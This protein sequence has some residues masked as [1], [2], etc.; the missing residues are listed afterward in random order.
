[1]SV[2]ERRDTPP[3]G[4]AGAAGASAGGEPG[5]GPPLTHRERQWIIV[6]VLLPTFLG[7]LDSTIL[8]SALPTIG[9]DIGHIHDLP[10]LITT[11]LL[12]ATAT[13]PLYG[14]LSDIH[15]RRVI[16]LVGISLY[17]F[18]SL[19]CALAP[20]FG[21]LIGGR[22]VHGLGGGALTG[23]GMVVLGDVA[24]PKQR[25]TYYGYFSVAYASAGALGPLLGGT[26]AQY[27]HW[28]AIFWMNVPAGLIAFT[29]VATLLRRLPRRERRHRLDILG[30][31][32]IVVATVSFM[33]A[34]NVGGIRYA[35]SSPA[36]LTLIG[37]AVFAAA[38]FVLR[39]V[40]AP[41]PLIPIAILGNPVARYAIMANGFGWGAI[42]GLNIFLPIYLQT[43]MGLSAA[44]AGLSLMALMAS[45][46]LSAGLGGQ[47]IGRVE[48]YKRLPMLGLL[49][50]I[51]ALVA[52]ASL[53]TRLTPAGFEVLLVLIGLGFGQV[54]PLSTVAMQ[55]A[56]PPHQFGTAIGTQTFSRNLIGTML[57]AVFAAIV[58]G[59]GLGA[60]SAGPLAGTTPGF[61]N[62]ALGTGFSRIFLAAA[63]TMSLS[64][65]CLC[66]ME[67]KPL[68]ADPL[69]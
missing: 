1:M 61:G 49:V 6:G 32:F 20:N 12:A 67:E 25:G 30:A 33:L 13:T 53:S 26:I 29:L 2:A 42:I 21:V 59:A 27:L 10:W 55:N 37:L 24:S 5:Q 9:R 54:A 36:V 40:T 68:L 60:G 8:A 16:L 28:S 45:V 48:R 41:E 23:L 66:L 39:L 52:M 46:N 14:K 7:S 43:V 47:L 3:E 56:V 63:A 17:I 18:G 65:L 11:Y 35:W 19:I 34:L 38:C 62:A 64:W 31:L 50:A 51:G 58:A 22:I 15:G 57:V 44:A 69:G 4:L